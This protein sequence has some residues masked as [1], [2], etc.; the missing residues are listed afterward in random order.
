LVVEEVL[1]VVM[2][3]PEIQELWGGMFDWLDD[4]QQ[5]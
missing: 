2:P 3:P 5:D 4:H 1:D